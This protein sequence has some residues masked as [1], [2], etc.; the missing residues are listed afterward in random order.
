VTASQR[1][2]R[3]IEPLFEAAARFQGFMKLLD[4]RTLFVVLDHPPS[5]LK[6]IDRMRW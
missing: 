6:T 1:W 4:S 3:F 5:I 2:G